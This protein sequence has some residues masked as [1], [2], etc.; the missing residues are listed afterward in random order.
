MNNPVDNPVEQFGIRLVGT[1]T[2]WFDETYFESGFTQER[3]K[4]PSDVRIVDE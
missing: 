2:P 3:V 4:P 1:Y